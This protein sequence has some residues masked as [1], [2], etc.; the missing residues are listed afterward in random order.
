MF[1]TSKVMGLSVEAVCANSE[2]EIKSVREKRIQKER[3]IVVPE[4]VCEASQY[5]T[6]ASRQYSMSKE[7]TLGQLNKRLRTA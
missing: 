7:G 3:F 4:A 6:V 5:R 1:L 2:T